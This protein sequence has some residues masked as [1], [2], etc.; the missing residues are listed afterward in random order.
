MCERKTAPSSV[1]F[2]SCASEKIWNPP[3]SV[4]IG[5]SQPVKVCSPP[6]ALTTFSPGRTIK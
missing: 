6:N 5:F 1:I 4:S 2:E 3:L